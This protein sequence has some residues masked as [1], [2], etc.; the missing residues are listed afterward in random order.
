MRIGSRSLVRKDR[1][2]GDEFIVLPN[3][4]R[5]PSGQ[6]GLTM[7]LTIKSK[8][9]GAGAG[10]HRTVGIVGGKSNQKIGSEQRRR[11]LGPR[12]G[13]RRNETEPGS[14]SELRRRL[15]TQS[16]STIGA[17]NMSILS[18]I[19]KEFERPSPFRIDGGPTP[20]AGDCGRFV[21]GP[22]HV[23]MATG[24]TQAMLVAVNELLDAALLPIGE[25]AGISTR[26]PHGRCRRNHRQ[27]LSGRS[28]SG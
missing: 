19:G 1:Q 20:H 17:Y 26:S 2:M 7:R 6:Q 15:K 5:F 21:V 8:L 10:D 9:A 13:A 25:G 3:R 16:K 27:D 24:Q 12:Q 28:R 22:R 18:S 11:A 4:E 14:Q 23:S